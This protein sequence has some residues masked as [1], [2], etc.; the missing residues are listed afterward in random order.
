MAS[1]KGHGSTPRWEAAVQKFEGI[2]VAALAAV[3]VVV[4]AIITLVA[5]YLFL[6]KVTSVTSISS[7]AELQGAAMRTFS[8]ILLVLLALELL[9]TVKVY[10]HEHVVRVEVVL[11]VALIAMGRHVLEIDLHEIEPLVLFGFSSLVLALAAGYYLVK[12]AQ[13]SA[14]R[15]RKDGRDESGGTPRGS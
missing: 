4:I 12:S 6:S 9:D 13:F 1:E 15:F 2:I 3:L 7:I 5:I 10:F 8:G 14:I 11:L